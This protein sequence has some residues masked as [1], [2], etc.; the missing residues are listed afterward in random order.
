[1]DILPAIDLRNGKCVRLLQGDYD[2]QI[3]YNDDP[4]DQAKRF[5]AQGARWLHVVD[6][7]G[8]KTGG[9][10]NYGV[11][12]KISRQTKLQI[13][14]GGGIRER[15]TIAALLS[16]GLVA[17]VIIGSQALE[18][19]EWFRQ[20]VFEFPGQIVLGLDA[21]A[22]RL[23]IHGWTRSTNVTVLEMAGRVDDWPL[24]AIAYTDIACDGMLGG[25]DIETT[26]ELTRTC[27]IPVI[28]AG[29]VGSIEHIKSLAT[30]E[31][32]GIIVGRALYEGTLCLRDAL[33]VVKARA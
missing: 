6:L 20:R 33:A 5:E 3:D 27:R 8:A 30:L 14:I 10:H 16:Q 25:P 32:A 17:R 1:M 18:Q 23:A 22:G 4:V 12:E 2:R 9:R 29:G 26:A 28:A 19:F 13:E 24:A 31:L 7:D 21:R 11:L 15:D